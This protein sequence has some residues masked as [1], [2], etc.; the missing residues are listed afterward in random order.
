MFHILKFNN[1]SKHGPCNFILT[2]LND[3]LDLRKVKPSAIVSHRLHSAPML[4]KLLFRFLF[5]LRQCCLIFFMYTRCFSAF[6]KSWVKMGPNLAFVLI[7]VVNT[8]KEGISLL[9]LTLFY[10]LQK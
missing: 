2:V 6:I 8:L 4:F 3:I 10:A 1:L 5:D 7:K 9:H